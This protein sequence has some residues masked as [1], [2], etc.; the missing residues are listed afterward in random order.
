MVKTTKRI[1]KARFCKIF[2]LLESISSDD[3]LLSDITLLGIGKFDLE[4][5][6]ETS[7]KD[8]F[9]LRKVPNHSSKY[10]AKEWDKE[11][12]RLYHEAIDGDTVSFT[13]TVNYLGPKEEYIYNAIEKQ[14]R[15]VKINQY[16]S[17]LYKLI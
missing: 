6:E 15:N 5:V 4:R 2:K 13:G 16:I 17:E 1:S 8:L 14:I 7:I 10:Y 12:D 3:V 9:P 11:Y